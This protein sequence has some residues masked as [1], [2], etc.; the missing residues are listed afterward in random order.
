[1]RLLDALGP[2][3]LTLLACSNA[4]TDASSGSGAASNAG[5]AA[6]GGVTTAGGGAASGGA[7]EGGAVSDCPAEPPQAE[8]ACPRNLQHCDYG[9]VQCHCYKSVKGWGCESCPSVMPKDEQDCDAAQNGSSECHYG[10]TQCRCVAGAWRCGQCPEAPPP[11]A[12]KCEPYTLFIQCS[13]DGVSCTCIS[14]GKW[15]CAPECPF[16]RPST[17]DACDIGQTE[18]CVYGDTMCTCLDGQYSCE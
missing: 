12:S 17:G 3:V 16:Q 15:I 8:T 6:A 11:Q 1:M 14:P 4:P 9:P 7:G 13:F 2:L 18:Q 5:G 10:D